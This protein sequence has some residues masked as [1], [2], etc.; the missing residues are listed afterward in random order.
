MTELKLILNQ[1]KDRLNRR[2]VPLTWYLSFSE[3]SVIPIK[4]YLISGLI[5]IALNY[6][7]PITSGESLILLFILAREFK[8]DFPKS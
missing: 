5:V 1:K 2:I 8:T 3:V 4:P 7:N 6:F